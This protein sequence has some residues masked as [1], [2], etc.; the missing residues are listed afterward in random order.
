M[1]EIYQHKES[2]LVSIF[3]V[4][5]FMIFMSVIVVGFIKIMGDEVRQTTDNDLTASALVSAQSGVEEGK[6]MLLYCANSALNSTERNRCNAALNQTDCKAAIAQFS[7][8]P[9][10]GLNVDTASGEGIVTQN[11]SYKQRYTCLT[12]AT[13]TPT[14]EDIEVP[15][16]NSKLIPLRAVGNNFS[17]VIVSWHNYAADKDGPATPGP[18]PTTSSVPEWN[19]LQ[20]PAM[21]RLEFIPYTQN[22]IDLNNMEAGTRTVFLTPGSTTTLVATVNLATDDPRASD[23]NDRA[24]TDIKPSRCSNPGTGQQYL[25][26]KNVGVTAGT[27]YMLRVTS[28]YRGAHIKLELRS[29]ANVVNFDN[30]QPLIDVTGKTNDVFRRIQ[31]RVAF[32]GDYFMPEFAIGTAGDICKQMVITDQDSSSSDSC[33]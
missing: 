25:C 15:V 27:N 21:L 24:A 17:N 22:N 31:S 19:A 8:V 14:V 4:I 33:R 28:Y 1:R 5:F 2:G 16:G 12:L 20:R 26:Q 10:L 29:G 9:A 30:V 7:T 11:E 32:E 13:Q 6:R 18:A 3:S 23:P